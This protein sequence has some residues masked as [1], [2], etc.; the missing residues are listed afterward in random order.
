MTH[1]DAF[2][3][4]WPPRAIRPVVEPEPAAAGII[5]STATRFGS[6]Q[7]VAP[8]NV[9]IAELGTDGVDVT[10]D[11]LRAGAG[12]VE[13]EGALQPE[14]TITSANRSPMRMSPANMAPESYSSR[15]I[16]SR[17]RP[18]GMA[19]GGAGSGAMSVCPLPG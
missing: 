15:R 17:S 10:S 18:C 4:Q 6:V 2:V 1:A 16:N 11:G 13:P 19:H 8:T 3:Q 12:T 5:Q 9:T 14:A 7:P